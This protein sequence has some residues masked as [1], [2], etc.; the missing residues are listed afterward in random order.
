MDCLRL[1]D[2][3]NIY[4]DIQK[5]TK[6]EGFFMKLKSVNGLEAATSLFPSMKVVVVSTSKENDQE[7]YIQS[8]KRW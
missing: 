5:F 8:S 2:A 1:D 3:S 6:L 4:L 7:C